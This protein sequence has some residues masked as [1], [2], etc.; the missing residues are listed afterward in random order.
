MNDQDY[1][2]IR[3]SFEELMAFVYWISKVAAET[4]RSLG[5]GLSEASTEDLL[6]YDYFLSNQRMISGWKYRKPG[7][8]YIYKIRIGQ[9][10]LI[11]EALKKEPFSGFS[12][13]NFFTGNL[14]HRLFERFEHTRIA[15]LEIGE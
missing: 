13:L 15:P 10:M 14:Q 6:L 2:S 9:A 11:Y 1:I 8:R 4:Y 5:S 12:N 7:K 3:V